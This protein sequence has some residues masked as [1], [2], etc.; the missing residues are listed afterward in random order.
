LQIDDIE[1]AAALHWQAPDTERLGEWLLRA[2][3]GF[4]GRANSALP[5][6]DPGRPL[7]EAVA[8]VAGWYRRRGMPPMIVVPGVLLPGAPPHPVE[9]YLAERKWVLRPG[10]AL[11]MVADV[12]EVTD[13]APATDIDFRLDPEPDA[14]WLA[15]YRYRGQQLPPMARTLLMS[16]PWQ[17]F[18]SIHR[19]GRP[20][21]V[22]R[23]SVA[24]GWAAITAVEVSS[25]TRRQGLGA[26]ITRA[27]A[28]VAAEQ[29]VRRI[30]LQVEEDN[31]PARSLYTRCGFAYS[32]RY[33]Y[34]I[35][36]ARPSDEGDQ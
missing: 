30:L 17:A 2:A 13:G 33:H 29:G 7:P 16:A 18:G 27:L 10:P 21:A 9:E 1:R 24:A 5:V 32:H 20:V 36:P 15:L 4:T 22:G 12:K 14:A 31:A 23:V 3:A 6:G 26:A 11:V 35:A 34:R 19:D 28:A 8:A 25:S